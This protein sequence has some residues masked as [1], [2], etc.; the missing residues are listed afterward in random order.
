M[1]PLLIPVVVG[2]SIYGAKK[3]L[4][5]KNKM[6]KAQNKVKKAK[7]RLKKKQQWLR[8]EGDILNHH[9]EEFALFKLHI[10]N[11]QIK[12]LVELIGQCKKAASSTLAH[13]QLIFT[14]EE[15]KTLKATVD[16]SLEISSGLGK[17]VAS[18]ALTAFGAYSSVGL[19]ASA[20]T[21]TAIASLSGAAATNATLAWLG[22]GSLAAGGFGVA[23]GMM[24]L[25]G[26][27]AGP[28]IAITG[29]VMDSKAEESLTEAKA[30]QADVD[31]A[32]AQMEDAV[33]DFETIKQRVDELRAVIETISHRYSQHLQKLHKKKEICQQQEAIKKVLILG[34]FLKD[35]LEISI[36]DEQGE[37]DTTFAGKLSR[38]KQEVSI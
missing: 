22:G 1:L 30:F 4:D 27:V 3:G 2:T 6:E 25:G 18:G 9:L 32:I 12:S 34:K 26:I 29:L 19:L 20:S 28:A 37:L 38:I 33:E 13:E 31:V 36:L 24:A 17:G 5:A 10:F 8:E 16:T 7:K 23:G 15:V 11:T 14:P 35:A 21:G